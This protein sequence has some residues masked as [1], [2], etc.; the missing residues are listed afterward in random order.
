MK[1]ILAFVICLF[2]Y[3]PCFSQ[4]IV[5][6]D[7]FMDITDE[8]L[9]VVLTDSI[10]SKDINMYRNMVRNNN[11]S[12]SLI[13]VYSYLDRP[14]LLLFEPNNNKP[15]SSKLISSRV[16]LLCL[17]HE[18]KSIKISH[19][20]YEEIEFEF[21]VKLAN[22]RAYLMPI[23]DPDYQEE[24]L[25]IVGSSELDGETNNNI[26]YTRRSFDNSY[27]VTVYDK[28]GCRYST[29][30]YISMSSK[31]YLRI[32]KGHNNYEQYVLKESD[33]DDFTYMTVGES[34]IEPLYIK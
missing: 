15:I 25:F 17:K 34:E 18:I 9:I 33:K 11:D 32:Q 23:V 2:L 19:P 30:L 29:G 13:I 4:L 22:G 10:T 1:N 20:A 28:E 6:E 31:S 7:L 3:Y 8:E 26:K 21:P 24:A 12:S 16:L 27:N 14:D 5:R